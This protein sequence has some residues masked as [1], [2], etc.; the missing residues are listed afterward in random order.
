MRRLLTLLIAFVL[1]VL[2]LAAGIARAQSMGV[3]PNPA[4]ALSASAKPCHSAAAGHQG[5][6]HDARNHRHVG[7]PDDAPA[8]RIEGADR[9]DPAAGHHHCPGCAAE[10]DCGGF[11]LMSCHVAGPANS[12]KISVDVA[13]ATTLRPH[14]AREPDAWLSPPQPPPPRA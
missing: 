11:C 8:V 4:Q 1:A 3:V 6:R 5:H 14:Q 9:Q 12:F 10:H 13:L 7:T 2:P